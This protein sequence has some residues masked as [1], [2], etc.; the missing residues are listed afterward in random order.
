[1]LWVLKTTNTLTLPADKTR[2]SCALIILLDIFV[3]PTIGAW[4]VHKGKFKGICI[5][6]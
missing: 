2:R 1:M 4:R 5:G 6:T 3:G